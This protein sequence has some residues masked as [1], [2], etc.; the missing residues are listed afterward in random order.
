MVKLIQVCHLEKIL[1]VKSLFVLK[2]KKID[3]LIN[4]FWSATRLIAE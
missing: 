4:E 3:S 1:F 2:A